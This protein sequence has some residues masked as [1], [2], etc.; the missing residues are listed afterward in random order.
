MKVIVS[1]KFRGERP[2]RP[3]ASE[4]ASQRKVFGLNGN[5]LGMDGCQVSVF[6]KRH[7]VSLSGFLQ[8]HDCG[9]LEA[10][11]GLEVLCDLTHESLEGEL[12][13]QQLSGLLV[14][15]DFTKGHGSRTETMGLLHTTSR[16][17]CGGLPSGLGGELFTGG[18]ASGSLTGE[19]G[20]AH[21]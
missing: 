14:P 12:P 5:A 3:L 2:L 1:D 4:T 13:D 20:R 18:F 15:S 7:E 21:V 9:G 8:C 19:I 16:G 17:R 10:Q 11:V 6:E